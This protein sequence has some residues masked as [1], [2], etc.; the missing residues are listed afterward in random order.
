MNG[1]FFDQQGEEFDPATRRAL[2][3][4][5]YYDFSIPWNFSFNYSVYYQNSGLRKNIT[6]TL[7]F[8]GSVTLTP[9]WGVSFNSGYDFEEKKLTPTT[10]SINRDLHC[11]QMSFSW[12][13]TGFMKSWSFNIHIK[14]NILRDLKY[15]KS[16]SHYDNI[17]Y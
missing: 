8:N 17:Y 6:Q 7:S 3:T 16:N 4:S 5:R 13:P 11:W 12:V 9:K 14:S 1:G 2:M 15:D 10:F